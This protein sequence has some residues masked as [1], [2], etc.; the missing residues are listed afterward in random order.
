MRE[1]KSEPLGRRVCLASLALQDR[2]ALPVSLGRRATLANAVQ[3]AQQVR[4]ARKA[5]KASK[6][7]PAWRVPL[8]RRVIAVSE[9][10]SDHRDRLVPQAR[11]VPP[12]LLVSS[13]MRRLMAARL[14]YSRSLVGF[15]P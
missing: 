13:T 6:A 2:R 12:D 1:V 15:C 14:G 10:M 7:F 9:V 4:L 3:P 11:K 8:E 5:F